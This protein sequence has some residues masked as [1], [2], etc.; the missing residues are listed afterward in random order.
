MKFEKNKFYHMKNILFTL[1]LLLSI[2]TAHSQNLFWKYLNGTAL[3]RSVSVVLE[4]DSGFTFFISRHFPFNLA[5]IVRTDKNGTVLSSN[6]HASNVQTMNNMVKTMDDGYVISARSFPI[7][8]NYTHELI[9]LDNSYNTVWTKR[10][11]NGS[12][13]QGNVIETSDS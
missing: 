2:P 11:F 3:N 4:P 6:G 1:A 8:N 10:Y 12:F 9:K 5:T 13:N 7:S